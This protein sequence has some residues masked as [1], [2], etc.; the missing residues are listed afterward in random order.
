MDILDR[1][2]RVGIVEP[3]NFIKDVVRSK[4][5]CELSRIGKV[6]RCTGGLVAGGGT[7]DGV[8]RVKW[9]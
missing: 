4:V 5:V 7:V 1:K 9:I 2:S 3:D 6:W 8:F